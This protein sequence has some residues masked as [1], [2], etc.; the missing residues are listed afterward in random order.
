MRSILCG[1]LMLLFWCGVLVCSVALNRFLCHLGSSRR[2]RG[3]HLLRSW[4]A[5]I[6]SATMWLLSPSCSSVRWFIRVHFAVIEAS[7]YCCVCVC[8][9]HH[10]AGFEAYI[11]AVCAVFSRRVRGVQELLEHCC[12]IEWTSLRDA[13]L[14]NCRPY[15]YRYCDRR[16]WRMWWCMLLVSVHSVFL[17]FSLSFV[18]RACASTSLSSLTMYILTSGILNFLISLSWWGILPFVYFRCLDSFR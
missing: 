9:L 3:V 15:N 18:L 11:S 16:M 5:S 17:Q 8:V 4:C 1:K 2:D 12:F 14:K 7:T 6:S 10:H 13:E